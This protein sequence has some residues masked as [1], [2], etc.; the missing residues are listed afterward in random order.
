MAAGR[1]GA[2]EKGIPGE[3]VHRAVARAEGSRCQGGRCGWLGCQAQAQSRKPDRSRCAEVV[4]ASQ[5]LGRSRI[6][7]TLAVGWQCHLVAA[8]A[9]AASLLPSLQG[10][11]MGD[12]AGSKP[13]K[14]RKGR[15][16]EGEGHR[17]RRRTEP[18][19]PPGEDTSLGHGGDRNVLGA[20]PATASVFPPHPARSTPRPLL[21]DQGNTLER[22]P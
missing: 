7:A 16:E 15:S 13:G 17:Y 8:W 6:P 20:V 4:E 12:P 2:P 11:G 5:Q 22:T 14:A 21:T 10:R 19:F 3:G 9:A 18:Q 1:R